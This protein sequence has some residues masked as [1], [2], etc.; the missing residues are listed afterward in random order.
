MLHSISQ[1]CQMAAALHSRNRGGDDELD[2]D[3]NLA[4]VGPCTT[5]DAGERDTTYDAGLVPFLI[6]W[7]QS[8]A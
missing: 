2:S 8:M 3:V 6:T 5:I 4:G 1:T 7:R